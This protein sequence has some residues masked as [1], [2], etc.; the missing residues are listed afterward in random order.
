[1]NVLTTQLIKLWKDYKRTP[2]EPVEH[3]VEKKTNY[4]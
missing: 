2:E 3:E 1:M 4:V